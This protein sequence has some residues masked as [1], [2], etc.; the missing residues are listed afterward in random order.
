MPAYRYSQAV[1][2]V[3]FNCIDGARGP[4]SEYSAISNQGGSVM[5]VAKDNGRQLLVYSM[6]LKAKD[7]LAM[8]LPLP[9]KQRRNRTRPALSSPRIPRL[10]SQP[11]YVRLGG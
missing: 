6:S 4:V 7:D 11:G 3:Q 10:A 5:V 9:E 1:I 8:L 2:F